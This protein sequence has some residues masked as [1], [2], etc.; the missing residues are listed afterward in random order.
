MFFVT[1]EF[2]A[3]RSKAA[4]FLPGHLAWL[5]RGFADGVFL[6]AGSLA[7]NAGGAV[8][9]TGETLEALQERLDADPFVAEGIVTARIVEMAPSRTDPRLAF[10][11]D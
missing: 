2:T 10:L 1:L 5:A 6:L 3:A 9:A 8:L 7:A 4:A 11:L